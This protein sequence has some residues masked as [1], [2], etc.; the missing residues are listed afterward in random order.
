MP[1]TL[2]SP[3]FT[4]KPRNAVKALYSSPIECGNSI[5][6][7]KRTSLPRPIPYVVVT[8]SPTP[9]TVRIADSSKGEHKYALAACERWCSQNSNFSLLIPSSVWSVVPTQSLSIIHEIID[10]RNTFQD[11]G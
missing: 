6:F 8:H 10:S 3:S 4:S 9:S 5:C 7:N 2:Y 1:I 11:C